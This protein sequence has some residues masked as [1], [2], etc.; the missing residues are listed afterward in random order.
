MKTGTLQLLP[1][2]CNK[3]IKDPNFHLD[4]KFSHN[5]IYLEYT[6]SSNLFSQFRPLD[7]D[8]KKKPFNLRRED[9]LWEK[10]CLEFFVS[11]TQEPGYIE[12]NFSL[13]GGWNV[14]TFDGYRKN[15]R[16]NMSI[17]L[18]S[19]ILEQDKEKNQFIARFHLKT[20]ENIQ[21]QELHGCAILFLHNS[22]CYF[23]DLPSL[24]IPPDFHKFHR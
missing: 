11:P 18:Q 14:F 8:T 17:T 3:K 12:F 20:K 4:Y 16:E 7:I 22:P 6:L 23:H 15:K 24:Q 10:N 21:L 2:P 1:T 13:D 19:Y 9:K 5:L